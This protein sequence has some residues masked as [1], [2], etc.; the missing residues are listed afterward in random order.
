MLQQ[1]GVKPEANGMYGTGSLF[2]CIMYQLD[3][4]AEVQA[5][6]QTQS[7]PTFDVIF[8][9]NALPSFHPA[10]VTALQRWAELLNLTTGRMVTTFGP[11]D[12]RQRYLAGME[13]MLGRGDVMLG[14]T[15]M[16]EED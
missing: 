7:P 14:M 6:T 4:I 2:R 9:R 12:V 1:A 8:A 10:C 11:T 15:F 5:M 16:F 13:C 3:L